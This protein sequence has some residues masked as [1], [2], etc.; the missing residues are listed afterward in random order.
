MRINDIQVDG[1][2]VWKGLTIDN[3]N[4]G[5]TLFYGRN[6]AGKTTLMQFVR[7]AMFGF[8]PERR[9]KYSPPVYGW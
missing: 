9:D 8:S 2:G 1:F 5:M 7:S 3:L 4:P 6:E